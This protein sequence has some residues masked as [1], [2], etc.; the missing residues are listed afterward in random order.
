MSVYV[1]Y[2]KH[3]GIKGQKWGVKNG[4]PYPIKRQKSDWHNYDIYDPSTGIDLHISEGTHVR[5]KS[6][7]AGKGCKT[8][9]REEV[10]YGLTEQYGGKPENWKHCKGYGI[11]DY[12]GEEREAEIHWFE[13]ETAGKHKFKI[14]EWLED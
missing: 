9:L 6:V 4:P 10:S 8:P 3:H 12:H 1:E 14:K 2:L 11:I 13:E 5:N 7:F